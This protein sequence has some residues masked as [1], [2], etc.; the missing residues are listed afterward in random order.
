M[1]TVKGVSHR[2]LNGRL[3]IDPSNARYR[4]NSNCVIISPFSVPFLLNAC[5]NPQYYPSDTANSF[6]N[7]NTKCIATRRR[8]EIIDSIW[9]DSDAR[10][11]SHGFTTNSCENGLPVTF[12]LFMA[13]KPFKARNGIPQRNDVEREAFVNTKWGKLDGIPVP[14][15]S[16]G[17][18]VEE[19]FEVGE[20]RFEAEMKYYGKDSPKFQEKFK[21]I[22]PVYERIK[23]GEK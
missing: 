12:E 3:F 13:K 5:F 11:D 9:L 15:L 10:G 2:L 16:K 23:N 4:H 17:S 18:I 8:G 22:E 1:L 14:V 21:E 7:E 20:L 6:F 19:G